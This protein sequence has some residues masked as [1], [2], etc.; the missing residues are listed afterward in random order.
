MQTY[1]IEIK[2][3]EEYDVAVI[4][5][6]V[7]GF[8]AAVAA[9]RNGARTVLIEKNGYFGGVA[10]AGRVAPFMTCYDAQGE[11]QIIGGIFRETVEKL[12]A[13]G[14]AIDPADC[15]KC[16]SYSGYRLKGHKGVTPFDNETLKLVL[17]RMCAEAGVNCL[18]H[19]AYL[20]VRVAGKKISSCIVAGVDGAREIAGKVFIDCTGNASV[21]SDAGGATMYA[22]ENGEVQPVSTFFV[23]DGVNREKLDKIILP[24]DD[25]AQRAFME[26]FKEGHKRGEL[27]CA[28]HKLRVFE[29]PGGLWAVNMCQIDRGTGISAEFLTRAEI[30]GREQARAIFQFLKKNIPGMENIRLIA[31]SDEVG[32]RESRRVAGAYILSRGDVESCRLFEDRIALCANSIDMHASETNYYKPYIGGPYSIPYRS[33]YSKDLENALT[34]GKTLSADRFALGAVRVMPPAFATGQA[35]GTA[36]A[37]AAEQKTAVSE[38]PYEVLKEKLLAAG[39]VL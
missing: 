20:G 22:D 23:I 11:K 12:L 15:R 10:T 2:K 21:V 30:E 36:A 4:G 16:D 8:S 18:Y 38:V 28:I 6:G 24:S 33:L 14:G 26:V 35:A 25:P 29:Q 17:D 7:A 39:A 5:G 27:P 13:L 9:A 1:E 19:T 3:R 32:V 37:I 34:A 31:T